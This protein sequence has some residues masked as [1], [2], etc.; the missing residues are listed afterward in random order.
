MSLGH[1]NI[2]K[3]RD[4]TRA[5]SSWL[6]FFLARTDHSCIQLV[7]PVTERFGKRITVGWFAVLCTIILQ[8]HPHAS[9]RIMDLLA[10][11]AE[12][13]ETWQGNHKSYLPWQDAGLI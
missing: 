7:T 4:F 13:D 2:R 8:L 12:S 10:K 5:L 1:E 9:A 11:G 3:L 6:G